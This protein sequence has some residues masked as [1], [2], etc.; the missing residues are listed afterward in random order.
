M[1][2]TVITPDQCG[3]MLYDWF[4]MHCNSSAVKSV[5][6]DVGYKSSFFFP[7]KRLHLLEELTFLYVSLAVYGVNAA[8]DDYSTIEAVVD[9]FLAKMRQPIL[10]TFASDDDGFQDRYAER[11]GSYFE[12]LRGGGDAIGVAGDFLVGLFGTPD[13]RLKYSAI[14]VATKVANAQAILHKAFQQIEV[15]DKDAL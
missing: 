9:A 2:N 12:L 14:K 15:R 5:S 7:R 10:D 6:R 11:V 8:L 4:R 1:A 13:A 3:D